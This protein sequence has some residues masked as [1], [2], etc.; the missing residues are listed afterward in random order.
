[1]SWSTSEEVAPGWATMKLACRSET[2]APPNAGSLETG[3]VD[4]GSRRDVG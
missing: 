2:S 3:L 1:M 4:Q